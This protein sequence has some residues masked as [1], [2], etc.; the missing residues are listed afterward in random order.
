MIPLLLALLLQD[1]D[2]DRLIRRLG[3][4]SADARSRA[5][6]DLERKGPDIVPALQKALEDADPEV[7]DRAK[8][9]LFRLEPT[10]FLDPIIKAQRPPK[11][12]PPGPGRSWG[13]PAIINGGWFNFGRLWWMEKWQ[14]QGTVINTTWHLATDGDVRWDVVAVTNGCEIPFL[15]CPVH[16]PGKIYIDGD[17]SDPVTVKIRGVRRWLCDVPVTFRFPKKGDLRRVGPYTV[18]VDWPFLVVAAR[19]DAPSLARTDYPPVNDLKCNVRPGMGF[20]PELPAPEAREAPGDEPA[21]LF[22]E[23]REPGPA[24]WCGCPEPPGPRAAGG[25][26]RGLRN[27]RLSVGPWKR[28]SL[29]IVDEIALNFKLPLEEPFEA[30]SAPL[31]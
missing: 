4:P 25:D 28:A 2:L 9:I 20:E 14:I 13:T 21:I 27:L 26:A 22:P 6:D 23:P 31:P 3:D 1:P 16:S 15:R 5:T 24:R 18:T 17:C 8:D 30:S 12:L 10:L 11:A 7:R 19:D 29:E